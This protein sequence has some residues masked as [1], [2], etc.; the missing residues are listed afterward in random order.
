MDGLSLPKGLCISIAVYVTHLC[1]KRWICTAWSTALITFEHRNDNVTQEGYLTI[2]QNE[3]PGTNHYIFLSTTRLDTPV[4]LRALLSPRTSA[5][6]LA[7]SSSRLWTLTPSSAQ[8]EQL[9]FVQAHGWGGNGMVSD[10]TRG[11]GG[12]V[13]VLC[14]LSDP[15]KIATAFFAAASLGV[16]LTMALEFVF[17]SFARWI[18]S[19]IVLV[20]EASSFQTCIFR[21]GDLLGD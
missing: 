17:A 7:T 12:R 15:S 4:F 13:L 20:F 11:S 21:C 10:G 1:T 3:Q 16:A 5:L 14:I 19:G 2:K 9:F 8:P 6:S 18:G